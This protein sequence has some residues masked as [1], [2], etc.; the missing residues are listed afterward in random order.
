MSSADQIVDIQGIN[1]VY[2]N[3]LKQIDCLK[4]LECNGVVE[5]CWEL[6]L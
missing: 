6:E 3:L 5:E 1:K 4:I 2:Q